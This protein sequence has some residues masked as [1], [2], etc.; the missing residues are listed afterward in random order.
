MSP[1][2]PRHS[3]DSILAWLAR[4]AWFQ[5]ALGVA[6]GGPH[7]LLLLFALAAPVFLLPLGPLSAWISR[8]HEY[9]A[10]EY[11]ARHADARALADALVKLYR[12]N[13]A[14]LTPD[15]VYTAFH[16]SHPPALARIARLTPGPRA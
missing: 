16:A 8:R 2:S 4:T 5:P 12:D 1:R 3:P 9:A 7:T 15:P 10:D 14:T 11:A 13:G 6:A